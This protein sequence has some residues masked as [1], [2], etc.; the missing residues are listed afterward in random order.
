MVVVLVTYF[1]L[2][3]FI[4]L[5][6]DWTIIEQNEKV[7]L[8]N[9]NKIFKNIKFKNPTYKSK[10]YDLVIFNTSFQYLPNPVETFKKLKV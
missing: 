5:N 10:K 2:K 3:N 9:K 7:K 4:H 6:F 1:S 8:A